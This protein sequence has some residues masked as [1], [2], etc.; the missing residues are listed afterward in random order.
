MRVVGSHPTRRLRRIIMMR[1]GVKMRSLA[2]IYRRGGEKVSWCRKLR[3]SLPQQHTSNASRGDHGSF[4]VSF[5][6]ER[7]KSEVRTDQG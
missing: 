7:R 2:H 3:G 6:D 1:N 4:P 5:G